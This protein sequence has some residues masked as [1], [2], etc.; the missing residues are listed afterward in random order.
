MH[1]QIDDPEKW[2]DKLLEND[3]EQTP[4]EGRKKENYSKIRRHYSRVIQSSLT[5]ANLI[6]K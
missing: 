4:N 6:A 3:T 2:M 1:K 5:S